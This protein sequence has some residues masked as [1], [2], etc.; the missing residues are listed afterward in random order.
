MQGCLLFSFVGEHR[1]GD[2]QEHL[3]IHGVIT[4]DSRL[5]TQ[6]VAI[7]TQWILFDEPLTCSIGVWPERDD[8][9]DPV[10]SITQALEP[11]AAPGTVGRLCTVRVRLRREHLQPGVLYWVK[12]FRDRDLVT[13]YPLRITGGQAADAH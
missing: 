12:V 3:V 5:D 10:Y 11:T 2:G 6:D 8:A 4:P 7:H 13:Q 9:S 1:L